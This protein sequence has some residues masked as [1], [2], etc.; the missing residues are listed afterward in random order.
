MTRANARTGGQ[1]LVDTL[2]AN[3]VDTVFQVAG[4]S[5]LAFLDALYDARDQIKCITCR[6][7]GGAAFMA[8]AYGKLTGKPGVVVVTRGPGACNASI[9]VHTAHQDSTPMIVLIGQ[10]ARE[11]SERE[12]FQEVDFRRMYGQL[13]KWVGQIEDA[14]RLPE[15]VSRAFHIATSGRP[16]PVV[17]AL[18]E[19][20]LRDAVDAVVPGPA[21][22]AKAHPGAED[23]GQLRT[24]L[25]KAERPFLLVGG[26]D[27]S[28]QA[29]AD[30]QA[31]AEANGIPTACS[32]RRFDVVHNQSPVFIGDLG[33]GAS[34]EL[35][36][37]FGEADLVIAV[38]CRLGEITTQGYELISSPE[39]RHTLVH[40]HASAEELGRVFRP[41]LAIQSGVGNFA[42]AARALPPVDG[43]K[44]AGWLKAAKDGYQAQLTPGAYGGAL[45]PG[46]AMV[47]LRAMLPKDAI[48]TVDAGNASG[49][50][51]RFLQFGRPGRFLGPTSGAMGYAV[52]AAVAAAI[53]HPDRRVVG[54]AGD[55]AFMMSGQE[56]ATAM[57]Y[58]AKPILIVMNNN[59]YGT[60]RMHQERDFPAR[61][62]GTALTNPDFASIA[63]AYGAHGETVERTADFAPAFKRALDSGKLALIEMK[64]DPDLITTRTTLTALRQGALAKQK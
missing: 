50:P 27:W 58:G 5:F 35:T 51:Q 31:F 53:V 39:P 47:A 13:A 18:P 24:M 14:A 34:R 37:R 6:Q 33:T 29:A 36:K 48:I 21:R 52:P 4:E 54:F 45:H 44:W 16:G 41:T 60:I 55:G 23:M 10:V 30:I 8:D 15:Y 22:P 17:L 3:G 62:H 43:K 63:R 1:L 64:T 26:S 7:E 40:V 42:A 19:D 38:G 46:E 56:I 25:A 11:Q 12:A 20:M 9:G 57:Q 32:F 2:L 49:W 59:M 28:D 61:I